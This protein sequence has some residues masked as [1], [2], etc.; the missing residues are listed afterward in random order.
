[1]GLCIGAPTVFIPQLGKEANSTDAVTSEMA[2]WLSSVF[3]YS[4]LPWVLI[5][6]WLLNAIGRKRTSIIMSLSTVAMFVVF[7]FSKTAN[8]LLITEI[9]TGL[10]HASTMTVTVVAIGEYSSPK[11]RGIFLTLKSASLLWGIW[12][13]NAIGTFFHWRYIPLMG[14]LCSL[15]TLTVFYWCE[16]PYWLACKGRFDECRKTHRWLKGNGR[17]SERELKKLIDSLKRTQSK[18]IELKS[19]LSKEFYIPLL[20]SI[21][22]VTQYHFSGKLVCSIYVIEILKRITNDEATAYYGM[23]ILDGVTV[24]STYIGCILCRILK[25]RTLLLTSSTIGIT[26]LYILAL[27]LWLIRI[28]VVTEIK[29]ASVLFLAAFSTSISCGPMIMATSLYG[30]LIPLRFKSVSIILIA[31]TFFGFHS[32][33]LK[34]APAIFANFG[35][36][37][38]FL[39]YASTSTLIA[40]LIYKYLPETKD[41]TLQEIEDYFKDSTNNSDVTNL[42]R[43]KIVS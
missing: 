35:L 26:F 19:L 42:V 15:H 4:A 27:Y 40:I 25:R 43:D 41:K 18:E 7:Y 12:T 1:M 5:L 24:I 39:F 21:L 30:E 14:I 13:S 28:E 8:D 10:T 33:L 2:S 37:G 3:G 36:D 9:L 22:V 23:L 17:A 6:C 29:M 34:L 38:M 11:F 31:F 32:T 20:L 16:S